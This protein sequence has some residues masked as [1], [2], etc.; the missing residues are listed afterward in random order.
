VGIGASVVLLVVGAIMT[1]ALEVTTEGIDLDTVGVILMIAGGL[2]L[3]ISLL[4][5]SSVAPWGSRTDRTV[6]REERYY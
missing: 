6:V 3:V 4:F 2:G 5:W 1:F